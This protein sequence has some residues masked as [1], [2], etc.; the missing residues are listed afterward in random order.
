MV[1]YG[2]RRSKVSALTPRLDRHEIK[3]LIIYLMWL[4]VDRIGGNLI[5]I[6]ATTYF[7]Y[8]FFRLL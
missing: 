5:L 3:W 4:G 2:E 7:A 6:N 1:T 8:F